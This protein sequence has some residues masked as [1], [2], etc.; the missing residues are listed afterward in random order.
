[1]G[2]L[3]VD[4]PDLSSLAARM[5]GAAAEASS[6]RASSFAPAGLESPCVVGA[7]TD[8]VGAW[9][10]T[11]TTVA[12]DA[13]RLADAVSAVSRL[14]ADVERANTRAAS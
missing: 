9:S 2:M 5:R 1:M 3:S 4:T 13:R 7:L 12:D 14:Y 6:L 10:G 8:F 11:L